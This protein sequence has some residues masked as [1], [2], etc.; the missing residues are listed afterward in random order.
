[1]QRGDGVSKIP[2]TSQNQG[3]P[4]HALNTTQIL[5]TTWMVLNK[6]GFTSTIEGQ[7]ETQADT[8][9]ATPHA[10]HGNKTHQKGPRS[11]DLRRLPLRARHESEYEKET[12]NKKKSAHDVDIVQKKGKPRFL[13]HNTYEKDPSLLMSQLEA[14]CA[15]CYKLLIPDHVP[16]T[17]PVYNDK[18]ELMKVCSDAIHNFK[19]IIEDP[20]KESD[21][22]IRSLDE[23]LLTIEMLERLD[24]WA[25]CANI[26]LTAP[27]QDEWIISD[28]SRQ[29]MEGEDDFIIDDGDQLEKEEYQRNI[30]SK[31]AFC[32]DWF[33][34]TELNPNDPKRVIIHEF[35]KNIS[36]DLI[37][38]R[39]V[40]GLAL[41]LV[42]SFLFEEDDL[43]R[44]NMS[45]NG[46]RIDFDM[47]FWNILYDYKYM[48]GSV[49]DR[50]LR[51][52]SSSSSGL[53]SRIFN[54]IAPGNRF[55]TDEEDIKKFPNFK[56]SQPFYWPTTGQIPE[57]LLYLLPG[58]FVPENAFTPADNKVFALLEKHPVFIYYKYRTFL[59]YIL[60]DENMYRDVVKLN[61]DENLEHAPP[62]V[63]AGEKIIDTFAN[64][65]AARINYF[66]KILLEMPDFKKF[67]HEDGDRAFAE[68]RREFAARQA[69][70]EL[71]AEDNPEYEQFA[72]NTLDNIDVKFAKIKAMAVD[73]CYAT[74][75]EGESNESLRRALNQIF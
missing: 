74:F 63:R 3:S 51:S 60:T 23:G 65:L 70:F 10:Y 69:N 73:G 42:A 28:S 29:A 53:L 67:M 46:K 17:R 7:I 5:S 66:E 13:K 33:Q 8:N 64:H 32:G 43:H 9:L 71:K 22:H 41:C 11:A 55:D 49:F 45:K 25:A 58:M 16:S 44:K 37:N 14:V 15:G 61:M 31:I 36:Q 18:H 21:L 56:K 52:V 2:T 38:F 57:F 6:L 4:W 12:S 39:I 75:A 35:I 20:L 40:K 26:D 50:Y 62:H 68:I 27:V 54:S 72:Q 24:Q 1:M 34:Q 48:V 19:D 59:K 47:S 30:K